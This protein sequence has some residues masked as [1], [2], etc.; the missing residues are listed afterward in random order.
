MRWESHDRKS[1]GTRW[2]REDHEEQVAQLQVL[3]MVS[4][5]GRGVAGKAPRGLDGRFDTYHR[6]GCVHESASR[7]GCG[8]RHGGSVD[9]RKVCVPIIPRNPASG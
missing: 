5:R 4:L 3:L 2:L 1:C 8:C 9:P 7:G 6:V